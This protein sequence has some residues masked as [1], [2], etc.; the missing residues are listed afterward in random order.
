MSQSNRSPDQLDKTDRVI[1]SLETQAILQGLRDQDSVLL[2][3]L[4]DFSDDSDPNRSEIKDW[5]KNHSEYTGD[6]LKDAI[7]GGKL[8]TISSNQERLDFIEDAAT[9]ELRTVSESLSTREC[10]Y[11]D[12]FFGYTDHT[13]RIYNIAQI[14]GVL[15][16]IAEN[17][18]SGDTAQNI[19]NNYCSDNQLSYFYAASE[20]LPAPLIGNLGNSP[21]PR[22]VHCE[23][24]NHIYVEF[25]KRGNIINRFDIDSGEYQSVNTVSRPYIRIHLD[26]GLVEA[27][28]DRAHQPNKKTCFTIFEEIQRKFAK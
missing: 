7:W 14:D 15:R 11:Y 27:A 12:S 23:D 20:D 26:S 8:Y 17:A 2:E 10:Y 5:V 25:W 6:V 16:E 1:D 18:D 21:R 24:D 22:L 9:S 28:G 3:D 4:T 19:F 13:T